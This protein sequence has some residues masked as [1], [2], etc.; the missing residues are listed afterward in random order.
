MAESILPAVDAALNGTATVLLVTGLVLI[1]RGRRVG[2]ARVMKSAAL[3]SAAFLCC[4]LYYHFVVQ[5][6]TGPVPFRREG[7]LKS[8]YLVLLASHVLLAI[9]NLPMV[10]TTLWL[11]HKERW[12]AHKR[13]ARWTFPLWL[14]VSVTGVIVYLALYRWNPPA[15]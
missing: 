7:V 2:H 9:V 1:K 8:A 3:V 14:Y 6:E 10:L 11:A 4:Y 15:G 5:R 12:S 13:L